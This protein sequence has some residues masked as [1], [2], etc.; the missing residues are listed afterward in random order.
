[1]EHNGP[2]SLDALRRVLSKVDRDRIGYLA[3][4]RYSKRDNMAWFIQVTTDLYRQAIYRELVI[5]A[6]QKS[7]SWE[8]F[9][10]R[11]GA[12][13]TQREVETGLKQVLSVRWW[14]KK[15]DDTAM[16]SFLSTLLHVKH[17]HAFPCPITIGAP[18]PGPLLLRFLP[19]HR[20]SQHAFATQRV[21]NTDD[22]KATTT[23]LATLVSCSAKAGKSCLVVLA[24]SWT[25]PPFRDPKNIAH[26]D[27]LAATFRSKAQFVGVYLSEAHA[28]DV[29]PLGTHV[30]VKHHRTLQE[31][32][33]AASR[34]VKSVGWKF[35]MF[36]DSMDNNFAKTL[37]SH[38]ERYFVFR[39]STDCTQPRPL[40]CFAAPG[41]QAG[42]RLSDLEH[43]LQKNFPAW[44][45]HCV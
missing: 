14:A 23:T 7:S 41:R 25:W 27:R 3:Q 45:F 20:P 13:V 4:K 32:V 33:I 15:T 16:L 31:R 21:C 36:L 28:A 39:S 38:P 18:V 35:P 29:W 19:G 8:R 12:N 26:R 44:R 2:L 42:Y 34:F 6:S 11:T 5:A 17:D 9:G 10:A 24:G 30:I 1:M 37:A 43:F 40:L 22:N